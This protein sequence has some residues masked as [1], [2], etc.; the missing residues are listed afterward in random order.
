MGVSWQPNTANPSSPM[1]L[2]PSHT[3]ARTTPPPPHRRRPHRKPEGH[4]PGPR[5]PKW[6]WRRW[7]RLRARPE[8]LE[9]ARHLPA[10][11]RDRAARRLDRQ[12]RAG[13]HLERLAR[14]LARG[15][16]VDPVRL[17][18]RVRPAARARWRLGDASG[19]RR[20]FIVGV[21]LFTLA[22]ALCGFAPNGLVLVIARLVQGFAGGLLTPQ[23]TALIQQ[24]FRGKERGTAFGLFG[25]TVGIATAIGPLVG[26][27]LITAFGTENGWRFVFFVN[28][29][30]G[31]SRSSWPS[32]TARRGEGRA[33]AE[34]RLRPGG[35]RPARRR[36][37]RAA[38][39]VRAVRG[40]EE[41]REVVARRRC[42]RVRVL[43]VL[44]NGGTRG[45][46]SP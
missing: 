13:V 35:H 24:L 3:T 28:L 9:G 18:A 37:R 10:R 15:R 40:V 30:W 44:W 16:A 14:R 23:V 12:R 43:F 42:G 25:A 19:R 32:G 7:R 8:P 22:S 29:P 17:R 21:A 27:L 39:A 20:M 45:R 11:R 2:P 4:H 34:A 33:R 38:A 5:S 36:G 1:R 6:R 46:R 41:Q 31:S 26:G